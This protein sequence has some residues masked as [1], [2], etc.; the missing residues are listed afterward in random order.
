MACYPADVNLE[1]GRN[2]HIS[3]FHP[4]WW[5][6]FVTALS[7]EYNLKIFLVCSYFE[8]KEIKYTSFG[9]NDDFNNYN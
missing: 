3:L 7:N 4:K 6:G 9:I 2:A 8:N 1:D 5:W